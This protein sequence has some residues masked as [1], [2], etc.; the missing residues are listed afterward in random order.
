MATQSHPCPS[1]LT[2]SVH[3]MQWRCSWLPYA[4]LAPLC[5]NSVIPIWMR[6]EDEKQSWKPSCS[7]A[8][9][10]LMDTSYL[11]MQTVPW[12]VSVP[13]P[14][15]GG[16]GLTQLPREAVVP[17]P[18]RRS[19]PGWMGPWAAWAG[20]GQPCPRQGLGKRGL[21]GPFQPKPFCAVFSPRNRKLPNS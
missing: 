18:W 17:H 19:R 12:S 7:T 20:G 2:V 8:H 14:L 13:S 21:W 3:W 6:Q 1:A 9:C 16:E 15:Q 10:L 4:A 11:H 5:C